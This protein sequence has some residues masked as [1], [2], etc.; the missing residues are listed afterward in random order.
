MSRPLRHDRWEEWAA[1]EEERELQ[2]FVDEVL[3][4]LGVIAEERASDY[5]RSEEKP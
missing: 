3:D 2:A 1:L 5:Q 4:E